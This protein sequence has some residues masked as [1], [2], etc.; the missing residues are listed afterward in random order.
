[1]KHVTRALMLVIVSAATL[2]ASAVAAVGEAYP[3]PPP[4]TN[5][6]G[7]IIV[8]PG[9]AQPGRAAL[10][11]TGSDLKPLWIGLV[12]FVV[13]LVLVV[14]TRRRAG[15]RRRSTMTEAVG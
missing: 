4:S 5:A 2:F 8:T 7:Q 12:L 11:T 6:A 9:A 3:P 1:M 10:A 15:L 14:A 13:G